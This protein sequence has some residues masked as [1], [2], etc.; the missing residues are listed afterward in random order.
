M[1]EDPIVAETRELR[2]QMMKEA[3]DTLAGLFEL[4]AKDQESYRARLVRLSPRTAVP[5]GKS[6]GSADER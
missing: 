2:D 4:L 1:S 5:L 6:A 3:G